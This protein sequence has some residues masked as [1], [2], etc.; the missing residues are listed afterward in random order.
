[1]PK[2]SPELAAGLEA[3]GVQLKSGRGEESGLHGVAL[4]GPGRKEFAGAADRRREGTWR[5]VGGEP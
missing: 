5:E 3:R 1:M 4:Q 2:V